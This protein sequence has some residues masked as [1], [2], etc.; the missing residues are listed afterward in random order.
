MRGDFLNLKVEYNKVIE[1]VSA[2]LKYGNSKQQQINWNT[3]DIVNDSASDLLDFAPNPDVKA[4]LNQ[5]DEEISPFLR[6]DIVFVM[7][8]VPSVDDFCFKLVLDYNLENI[9][10][11]FEALEKSDENDLVKMI[12]RGYNTDI[13]FDSD[14]KLIKDT[15]LKIYNKDVASL[16]MQIKNHPSEFK[17]RMIQ[18]MKDFYLHFYKPHQ[19]IAYEFMIEKVN[20]HNKIISENAVYFIN[21]IGLGDYTKLLK[22]QKNIRIFVS[23]FYDL[24][25][26]HV[27]L[28][29]IFVLFYG[30]SSDQRFNG[31]LSMD[32]LKAFFKALSDETRLEIIRVTS[33]KAWYQK[34][35]ADYLGLTTPTLSYH[36]NLLLEVGILNFEPSSNNRYYYTTNKEKLEQLLDFSKKEMLN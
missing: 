25:M 14:D 34:E 20:E 11:F 33:K 15:L 31:Q 9:E 10:D 1:F 17:S 32:K 29:N 8:R 27:G 18:S 35:L 5:V 28:D 12:C 26:F 24:G 6:N 23:Y 22:K 30:Q 21:T 2:C 13:P 16:F 19:Q 3:D 36:V 4:W 7:V